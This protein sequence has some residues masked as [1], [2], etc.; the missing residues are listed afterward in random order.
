MHRLYSCHQI[1][2]VWYHD[3]WAHILSGKVN[4][5]KWVRSTAAAAAAPTKPNQTKLSEQSI[6]TAPFVVWYWYSFIAL[7]FP[8]SSRAVQRCQTESELIIIHVHREI[9]CCEWKRE[10][11]WESNR[12]WLVYENGKYSGR[13]WSMQKCIEISH[14]INRLLMQWSW[15]LNGCE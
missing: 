2:L 1:I 6:E 7:S 12:Y 11:E 14:H 15:K 10:R 8:L 4:E 5:K 13:N 9:E 3:L